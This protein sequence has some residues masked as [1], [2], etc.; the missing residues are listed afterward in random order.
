MIPGVILEDIPGAHDDERR[1]LVPVFNMNLEGFKGAEQLKLAL[2]KKNSVLGRHY[3]NYAE[4]FTVYGGTATFKL[5][6]PDGLTEEYVIHQG[7]RLLI[8]AGVW[9]EAQVEGGT[10][11]IGLTE[12]RYISPEH[13]DKRA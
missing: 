2:L 5:T 13:N 9:H 7:Q 12:E 10:L 1:T 6:S 3:H 4:L 11:L 8:P